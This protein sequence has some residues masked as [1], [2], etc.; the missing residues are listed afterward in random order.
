MD[1]LQ[2]QKGAGAGCPNMPTVLLL[3]KKTRLANRTFF[4]GLGGKEFMKSGRMGRQH[5][6]AIELLF[7]CAQR[8]LEGPKPNWISIRLIQ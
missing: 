3:G 5:S 1:L 4:R 6:R 7:S 2:E 8:K